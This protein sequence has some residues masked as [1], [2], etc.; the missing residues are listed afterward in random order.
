MDLLQDLQVLRVIDI[1]RDTLDIDADSI[2]GTGQRIL[3]VQ[4]VTDV[5]LGLRHH[6]FETG[7]DPQLA[8]LPAQYAG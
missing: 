7:I 4:I 1:A 6:V 8:R 2:A 3:V 5:L